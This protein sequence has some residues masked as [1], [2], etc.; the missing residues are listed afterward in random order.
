MNLIIFIYLKSILL[1]HLIFFIP[2]SSLSQSLNNTRINGYRGIWFELNEKY[3]YGDKYSGGLGT[4]TSHHFPMAIY[5]EEVD[6]TFFVY[7]GTINENERHLLCMAGCYDHK[8][9]LVEKPIV[10]FDKE[11]VNDPHDNPSLLIDKDGYIWVFISGRSTKRTGYKYRSQKPFSIEAFKEISS[12]V[13]TYPQPWQLENGMIHLFTKY[14][15]VRELYFESSVDGMEWTEDQKLAG[16]REPGDVKGGHYQ[17]SQNY[18]NLVGA[19]FNRHPNGVVNRRTDL[20]YLQTRDLGKTWTTVD[21]KTI[22]PPLEEVE[23]PARVINY[24]EQG[25]NVYLCDINF[26]VKGNPVCLYIT[27]KGHEPGPVNS[28]YQWRVTCWNGISW[29]T[30]IAGESDHNYDMGS[31]IIR[32]DKW[33]IVAP[34]LTGPQLWGAGGEI[35]IFTSG[36]R[37]KTWERTRQVTCNSSLNQNYV[38]RVINGKDPFMYLWA[39]GDPHQF[40]ISHIYFG[41]LE[42]NIRILP[43]VMKK[44]WEKPGRE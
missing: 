15:G 42:G 38:R 25:L 37:G 27:S 11:G 6:K 39:D 34:M 4:Y 12:E 33:L 30:S 18:G 8:R 17:V 19:F 7:G 23:N 5:A 13:M 16:I 20:Y 1:F 26:D 35:A 44:E 10:V 41:D 36:D 29:E 40:S 43:Y 22:T 2:F 21:G 32:D 24:Q 14:T 3:P 9:N 31:L 28:P